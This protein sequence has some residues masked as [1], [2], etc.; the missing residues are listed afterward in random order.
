M[1]TDGKQKD[2]WWYN[3]I[4]DVY[5]VN[6]Q[7]IQTLNFILPKHLYIWDFTN[8]LYLP[9]RYPRDPRYHDFTKTVEV[10]KA[11]NGSPRNPPNGSTPIP[12]AKAP[13]LRSKGWA[14]GQGQTGG[15]K[16]KGFWRF[17]TQFPEGKLGFT[18]SYENFKF[19]TRHM[20]AW[21]VY[22]KIN[23]FS[24][25]MLIFCWRPVG[26]VSWCDSMTSSQYKKW[27]VDS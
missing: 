4:T 14:R 19:S 18:L 10:W 16:P 17:R 1:I 5:L 6:K 25:F 15:K 3:L 2:H 13:G 12:E 21:I 27:A 7:K 9:R 24:S 23:M 26:R 22:V 11:T 20:W 8:R